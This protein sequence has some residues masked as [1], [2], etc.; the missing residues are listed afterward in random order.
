MAAQSATLDTSKVSKTSAPTSV[1]SSSTDTAVT[2][3]AAA[4]AAAAG[5]S[6]VPDDVLALA[7]EEDDQLRIVPLGGGREVGRSCILLRFKG[8]TVMLDCGIHPGYN[9][10]E[11]LPHTDYLDIKEVDILLITHFHIDHCG[12]LPWLLSET[13][14]RGE[15]YMTPPTKAI[16]KWM[17]KDYYRVSNI[18]A[19]AMLY[20]E[21]SIERS[22]PRIREIDFHQDFFV[23]GIHFRAL[24]AGHVLGAAMFEVEIAGVRVLYTGDY[25]R[26]ED[27][28]LR[29]AE[30]PQIRPDVVIVESTYGIQ[31]H[32]DRN[33]RER[34]FTGAVQEIVN[35]GGRCLVPVFALG[36]AQELLLILDEY[37][38]NHPELQHIPIYYASELAN[39]CMRIYQAFPN[40]M[41]ARVQ[42]QISS[43]RNPFEF[44]YISRV[45]DRADLDEIGAAVVL[46]SPGMLQSGLSRELIE[47]W[48]P[49]PK[50]GCIIAGYT[51]ERTLGR[52][53]IAQPQQFKSQTGRTIDRRCDISYI[54]FTAHADY[55]QTSQFIFELVPKHVILVHGEPGM[56]GRLKEKM[57]REKLDRGMNFEIHSPSNT[58]PVDLT[59][60][61]EK[62]AKV[63]GT[64]AAED[65]QFGQTLSGVLIQKSFDYHIVAPEDLGEYTDL[66]TSVVTQRQF[67][68]FQHEFSLLKHF[69]KELHGEVNT[70][71]V[72]GEEAI[73]VMDKITIRHVPAGG[74][75]RKTSK[76]EDTPSVASV[77]LEWEANAENDI[78]A[79]AVLAALLQIDGSPE[80]VRLTLPEPCTHI[81]KEPK[82]EEDFIEEE[83]KGS[84]DIDAK[85]ASEYASRLHLHLEELFGNVTRS[86]E[87]PLQ[88][89]VHVGEHIAQVDTSKTPPE[90]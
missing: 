89:L 67:V 17:L 26:E 52:T 27:R 79:D 36:R 57:D 77:Q 55:P 71:E 33:A 50:N 9:G 63:I 66:K 32:E 25:N 6:V 8:K 38:E 72:K 83:R 31:S 21:A 86:E 46:A 65:P 24:H 34:R 49:N 68:P 82:G 18:S 14:F 11:A 29:A 20:D 64:I 39:R 15:V 81:K 59:F 4:A 43:R 51:V 47:K 75:R 13:E 7:A 70:I 12:A 90:V 69:L 28:H 73:R 80:A 45:R 85:T 30:M 35:R 56:I 22:M 37:W 61:G 10:M 88:I 3:A 41:N 48:A 76:M 54:S 60:R 42:R 19:S 74:K 5:G 2:V 53:L 87:N 40:A 62:M 44:E 1:T 84:A 78:W 23:N 58:E 16:Y